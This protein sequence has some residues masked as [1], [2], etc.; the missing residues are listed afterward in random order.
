MVVPSGARTLRGS[1]RAGARGPVDPPGPASRSSAHL[2]ERRPVGCQVHDGQELLQ[3]RDLE[4]RLAHQCGHLLP[5]GLALAVP[6]KVDLGVLGGREARVQRD[7]DRLPAG[8]PAEEFRVHPH[9]RLA[10][11][12]L[13][14][15][16]EDGVAVGQEP[17]E[18]LGRH[19][20]LA[21]RGEARLLPGE[22]L[23]DQPAHA[24]AR[25]LVGVQR[26]PGGQDRLDRRADRGHRRG[27]RI[28]REGVGRIGD[29]RAAL[30]FPV[31]DAGRPGVR[32]RPV[33]EVLE[34][35]DHLFHVPERL[36]R[37]NLGGAR[38][39]VGDLARHDGAHAHHPQNE[40][41]PQ[42]PL[43]RAAQDARQDPRRQ[44]ARI[45]LALGGRREVVV[46][47]QDGPVA[48]QRRGDA[49]ESVHDGPRAVEEDDVRVAAHDLADQG[50]GALLAAEPEPQDALEGRLLDGFQA[51]AAHVFAQE[52]FQ[53]GGGLDAAPRLVAR[54]EHQGFLRLGADEHLVSLA[55]VY[56][57]RHRQGGG[58]HHP[59]HAPADEPLGE[60]VADG[61]HRQGVIVHGLSP[62]E[63]LPRYSIA[64]ANSGAP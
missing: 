48:V 55:G 44:Q 46:L 23:G 32:L 28:L 47:G 39:A 62:S 24:P 18:F 5:G 1:P 49:L 9:L 15:H 21:E 52:E 33:V 6:A 42:E 2:V 3:V 10:R 54:K 13:P 41:A 51:G 56:L 37:R 34:D 35:P 31:G 16:G 20:P 64:L 58:L 61:R 60:L 29:G 17:L 26:R 63:R 36:V 45:L 40:P 50:D 7:D 59:L 38:R 11:A 30:R 12:D 8:L 27:A 53:R 25:L 14:G 43:V 4:L 19:Q 22:V 57:Q